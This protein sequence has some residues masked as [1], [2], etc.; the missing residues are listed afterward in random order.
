MLQVCDLLRVNGAGSW[1]ISTGWEMAGLESFGGSYPYQL[2]GGMRQRVG[3]ARALINEPKVLLMD[4]PFGAL[5]AMT[6]ERLNQEIMRIWSRNDVSVLFITHSIPEAVLLADR[7]VVMSDRP[8]R[9]REI[10]E[11]DLPRPRSLE[12][13]STPEFGRKTARLRA[14]FEASGL[15]D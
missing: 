6:R 4:E 9:V 11:N 1:A 15:V 3:I 14:L 13:M 12:L 5:D 10:I 8:G 7:I 2:S